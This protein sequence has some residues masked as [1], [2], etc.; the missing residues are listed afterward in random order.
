MQMISPD[1]PVYQAG[2]LSGNPVA[3]TAGIE[4]LNILKNESADYERL[5]QKTRKLADAAREAGKDIFVL[6]RLDL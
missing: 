2:T 5:E 3:T 6:I 4:T 1:G